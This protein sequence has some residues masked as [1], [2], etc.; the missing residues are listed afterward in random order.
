MNCDTHKE[1]FVANINHVSHVRDVLFKPLFVVFF[2]NR[3]YPI[4]DPADPPQEPLHP[5]GSSMALRR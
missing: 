1:D 2:K 5:E 4:E 3:W